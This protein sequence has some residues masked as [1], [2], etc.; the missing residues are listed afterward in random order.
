MEID[1]QAMVLEG[2][3][4]TVA[5]YEG[6]TLK[7]KANMGRSKVVQCEGVLTQI[8]PSLFIVEVH[9]KRGRVSRQSYQYADVLTGI[10]ELTDPVSNTKLFEPHFDDE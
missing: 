1:Q 2:I 8:H 10:V 4:S 9:G 7:I 6:R 3:Q 5:S